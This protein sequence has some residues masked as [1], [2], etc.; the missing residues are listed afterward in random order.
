MPKRP[1]PTQKLYAAAGMRPNVRVDIVGAGPAGLAV[2]LNLVEG[3]DPAPFDIHVWDRKAEVG[4]TPC[5]E[6]LHEHRLDLLPGFDSRPYVGALL[7]GVRVDAPGART[8]LL[9]EPCATMRRADWLPAIAGHLESAGVKFHLGTM[10]AE[11]AIRDLPGDVVVGADGPSSRVARLVGNERRYV[12]ATQI[13]IDATDDFDGH[14]IF[15]W[16]PGYSKDYAW[17]FPRGDHTSVGSLAPASRAEYDKLRQLA[18]SYGVEGD[19]L[20]E[21]SYPIPFGGRTP[22]KGRYALVGDAAGVANPLTKGGMAPGFI[23]A[24]LLA[25]ALR[26]GGLDA[27]AAACRRSPIY[28]DLPLRGLE[29]LH[30]LTPR[31]VTR[32]AGRGP[33]QIQ[34]GTF[35]TL[36]LGLR[37]ALSGNPRLWRDAA[38]MVRALRHAVRWG[39]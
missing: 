10:L 21:E 18:T 15:R 35:A 38:V 24:R 39:W 31:D 36:R 27:Y 28:S 16:D 9:D 12:P 37:T 2:A 8:L 17:L 5:G 23:Q 3:A 11:A 30:R 26:D 4:T 25:D 32:I 34:L 7:K 6:G 33:G 20:L 1:A 14:L 22:A 19:V 13:R 29:T